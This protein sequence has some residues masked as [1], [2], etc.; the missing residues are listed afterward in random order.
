MVIKLNFKIKSRNEVLVVGADPKYKFWI[1][2]VY[3]D[4][5]NDPNGLFRKYKVDT[6]IAHDKI[7]NLSENKILYTWNEKLKEKISLWL[8]KEYDY[9]KKEDLS[10]SDKQR[11]ILKRKKQLIQ[12]ISIR[13]YDLKYGSL[14]FGLEIAPI[15]KA[16]EIFDNNFDLFRI[17]FSGFLTD[18]FLEEYNVSESHHGF[19]FECGF[20]PQNDSGLSLTSLPIQIN[21]DTATTQT[22]QPQTQKPNPPEIQ[23]SKFEKLKW[24]WTLSNTSLII[25]VALLFALFYYYLYINME[26]KIVQERL[27]NSIY[28]MQR[29]LIEESKQSRN[30]QTIRIDT[31]IS[32]IKNPVLRKSKR[33]N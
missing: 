22:V 9:L 1:D 21:P 33:R 32:E 10:I 17:V 24:A 3:Q 7:I 25:P 15:E 13:F 11:L 26:Q 18:L 30:N 19:I 5:E 12:E 23:L 20:D 31:I 2:I 27:Y 4:G 28:Q 29:E 6:T 14:L 16:L 8:D